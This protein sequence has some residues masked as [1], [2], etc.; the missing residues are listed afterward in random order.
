MSRT[1]RSFDEVFAD[2]PEPRLSAVSLHQWLE[3]G[4]VDAGMLRYLGWEYPDGWDPETHP[5]PPVR[6]GMMLP[7][8]DGERPVVSVYQPRRP[9]TDEQ[10]AFLTLAADIVR[11][12]NP[13]EWPDGAQHSFSL[14]SAM[15]ERGADG[16]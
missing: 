12:V 3:H 5:G 9:L 2:D 11:A 14:G 6:V 8:P 4:H 7:G 13:V 10:L 1:I 16:R 15:G